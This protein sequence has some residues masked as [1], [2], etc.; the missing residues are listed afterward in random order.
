MRLQTA[1]VESPTEDTY[2]VL[3]LWGACDPTCISQK[4]PSGAIA[5]WTLVLGRPEFVS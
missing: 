4:Q 2:R 5:Q 3:A 1:H